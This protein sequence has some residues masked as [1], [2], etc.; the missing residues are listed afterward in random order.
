M[1]NNQTILSFDWERLHYSSDLICWRTQKRVFEEV[2]GASP[3]GVWGY[4]WPG[5][6]S[7]REERKTRAEPLITVKSNSSCEEKIAQEIS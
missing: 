5:S 6:P 4:L 1:P 7:K 2:L 3:L